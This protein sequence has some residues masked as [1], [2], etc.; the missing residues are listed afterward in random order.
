MTLEE[1]LKLL[2]EVRSEL[3]RQSRDIDQEYGN[4]GFTDHHEELQLKLGWY[5]EDKMI[6][7]LA[8]TYVEEGGKDG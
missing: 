8:F 4:N 3:W 1:I 6:E 2:D 5:L 7:L